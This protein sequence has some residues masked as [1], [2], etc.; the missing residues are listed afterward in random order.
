MKT[1]SEVALEMILSGYP[2]DI[3]DTQVIKG[4]LAPE[5]WNTFVPVRFENEPDYSRRYYAAQREDGS[6]VQGILLMR[7]QTQEDFMAGE[8]ENLRYAVRKAPKTMVRVKEL[9]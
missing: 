6:I 7:G 4:K 2:D 9:A 3:L 1:E 8:T 5:L